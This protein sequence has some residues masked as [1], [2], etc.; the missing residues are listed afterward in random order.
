MTINNIKK[1]ELERIEKLIDKAL[2]GIGSP[3]CDRLNVFCPLAVAW[4][5]IRQINNG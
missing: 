2:A 4:F 5:L 3:D 1:A